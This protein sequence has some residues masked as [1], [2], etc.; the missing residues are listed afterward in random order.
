MTEKII[1]FRSS[2]TFILELMRYLST[3]I[4]LKFRKIKFLLIL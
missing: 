1:K 2:K 3:A 4:S